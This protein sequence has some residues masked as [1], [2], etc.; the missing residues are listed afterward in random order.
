MR[1]NLATFKQDVRIGARRA[2]RDLFSPVTALYRLL[3]KIGNQ[4][5]ERNIREAQQEHAF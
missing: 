2:F 1:Y 4:A 3:V 5:A